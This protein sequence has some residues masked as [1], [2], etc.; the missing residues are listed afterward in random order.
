ME[1]KIGKGFYLNFGELRNES[2]EDFMRTKSELVEEAQW[3]GSL[4]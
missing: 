4:E 3:L 1:L 2:C